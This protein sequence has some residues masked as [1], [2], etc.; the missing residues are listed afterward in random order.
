MPARC[1]AVLAGEDASVHVGHAATRSD[2]AHALAIHIN[3]TRNINSRPRVGKGEFEP[4]IGDLAIDHGGIRVDSA[5]GTAGTFGEG[6]CSGAAAGSGGSD[7]GRHIVDPRAGR[8]PASDD[9]VLTR[10]IGEI[11]SVVTISTNPDVGS[12]G[13]RVESVEGSKRFE[14]A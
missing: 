7:E 10:L 1:F 3:Q 2:N 12:P 14:S 5:A 9:N 8:A 6:Q 11:G 13:E 4:G